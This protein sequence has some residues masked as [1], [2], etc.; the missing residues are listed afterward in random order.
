M[1]LKEG[2][3]R[4]SFIKNKH[5]NKLRSWHL[6]PLL[7]RKIK[8]EKVEVVTYFLFLDSKIAMDSDHSHEIRKRLFLGREA[9]TN[10]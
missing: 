7:H 3:K 4:V 1:M 5:T 9:M 6:A 8:R 10:L 2:S